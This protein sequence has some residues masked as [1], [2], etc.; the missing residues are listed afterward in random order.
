MLVLLTLLALPGHAQTISPV[1]QEYGSKSGKAIT[2]SF[3]ITNN[4]VVPMTA[5]VQHPQSLT[6]VNG[7]PHLAALA[8]GVHVEL[9]AQ[10]ARLGAKQTHTFNYRITTDQLPQAITFFATLTRTVERRDLGGIQVAISLPSTA[11]LC[12][13][14]KGCRSRVLGLQTAAR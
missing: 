12:E 10:S 1:S 7:Q 9:N 6:F 13:K 4:S 11:Y 14:Q 2:G 5:V 8:P 3:T